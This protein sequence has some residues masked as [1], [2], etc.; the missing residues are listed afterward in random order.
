MNP[1]MKKETESYFLPNKRFLGQLLTRRR[2][3]NWDPN[4]SDSHFNHSRKVMIL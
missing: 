1:V 3:M 2:V 4:S